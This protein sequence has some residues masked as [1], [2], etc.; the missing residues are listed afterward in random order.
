M[1]F[2][3]RVL[4]Q[5][6]LMN[7]SKILAFSRSLFQH[8]GARVYVSLRPQAIKVSTIKGIVEIKPFN[9]IFL[10]L[11]IIEGNKV[12]VI[13]GGVKLVFDGLKLIMR[14]SSILS[15]IQVLQLVHSEAS[16]LPLRFKV[17]AI[18]LPRETG[19]LLLSLIW[20]LVA[21]GRMR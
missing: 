11:A 15:F 8:I 10:G 6:I 12:L 19:P 18:H 3:F 13:L 17:E 16:V 9:D 1:L 21:T 14:E 2:G 4:T 20:S 5:L 7:R